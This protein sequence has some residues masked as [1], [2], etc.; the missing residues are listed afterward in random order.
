MAALIPKALNAEVIL[1]DEG[2]EDVPLD[3]E[4]DIIGMTVITGTALRSYE[5]ADSY[6]ARGIAVVLGGPHVTL[7][8][9][10]AAEHADSV[11]TG[12][13]EQSWPAAVA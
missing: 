9:D 2:I 1:Y 10:E 6:R 3:I 4:A 13:A 11:V 12:Y 8:P 5:L 7:L